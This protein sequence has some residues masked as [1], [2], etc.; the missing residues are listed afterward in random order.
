MVTSF[1]GRSEDRKG[2]LLI[3]VSALYFGGA[4]KV[5][6]ILAALLSKR[7][8][9]TV[10]YCYDS[11]RRHSAYK[12]FGVQKL[13]DYRP[14]DP[15][16][17]KVGCVCKQV[18]AL[19]RLKKEL[20]VDVALS[21]G[22]GSNLI[23]VLSRG[24]ERVVCCERCNPKRSWGRWFF[25]ATWVLYRR[26]D[27]VIFQSAT[28]QRLYGAWILKKSAILNNPIDVPAPVS[29]VRNKKIVAL[30]RLTAQKNH[31]LLVRSFAQFHRQFSE[32]RLHIFGDGELKDA[33]LR[34]IES[35]GMADF[36]FLEENDPN[37]H[38]RIR[39][40]EMF[41]L[42]SDFEGLSNALLECMSMGIA[43]ISTKCEGSTDV[44][45][46]GENG[47][48]VEIGDENGLAEAMRTL[49]QN[50]QF[51]QKLERRAA[52][53]MKRYDKDVVVDDWERVIRQVMT[54][55]K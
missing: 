14:N 25:W 22:N 30:G 3:V 13:P 11:E 40:A 42:S 51:R 18:K 7:F 45:R 20:N 33:M 36:V 53:D 26:A 19:S 10:A 49:A 29:P 21:L 24:E 52:E 2:N 9:V 55:S 50:P 1:S 44:I 8:N 54:Q 48:L 37:V 15:L 46:H 35:L 17:Q 27:F 5:A 16:W 38:E 23:N 28:I 41:V 43:C 6:C 39:D 12:G 47:A 34:L 31:A 32:Y 4:Q